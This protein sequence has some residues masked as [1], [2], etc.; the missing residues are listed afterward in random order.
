MVVLSTWLILTALSVIHGKLTID[1]SNIA[2]TLFGLANAT[3]ALHPAET[4]HHEEDHTITSFENRNG[5]VNPEDLNAMPQCV[6]QQDQSAWLSAMTRCT[7]RQCTRH[8]GVVCTHHQW[9]TQL[10]CLSTAFSPETVTSYLP[11][12]SRS[13]LAKA[14]LFRWILAATGRTWLVHVG[15]ASGLQSLTPASLPEGYAAVGVIEKAPAC[16]KESQNGATMEPFQ[17]VIASCSFTSQAQHTGNAARPWEYSEYFHSMVALDFETA[18]YDL[19][20]RRIADGDYFDKAC[21]C[22]TLRTDL[23]TES[24]SCQGLDTTKERLWLNATCG[25]EL[26]PIGWQNELKTTTFAFIPTR[27][28]R[29]PDC[30]DNLPRRMIQLADHCT[31]DACNVDSEG[32][33]RVERAIDRAQFCRGVAYSNCKGPCRIFEARIQYV[34]WLHD[35]CGGVEG[36]RGLPKHWRQLAAPTPIEMIPWRWNIRASKHSAVGNRHSKDSAYSVST[37]WKVSSIVL[38]NLATLLTALYAQSPTS[39][40]AVL[41]NPYFATTQHCFVSGLTMATIHLSANWVNAILVQATA[42]YEAV[43]IV[44]LILLW[45]TMPRLTWLSM[46]LHIIRPS[47]GTSIDRI[48]SCVVVETVLQVMSAF[49]MLQTVSYG[50]EH[51]FYTPGMARLDAA[52]SAKYMYA[53]A[54]TWLLVTIISIVLLLQLTWEATPESEPHSRCQTAASVSSRSF[55]RLNGHWIRFEEVLARH[56]FANK[57][58]NTEREPLLHDEARDYGTLLATG[59]SDRRAAM[60]T[61]RFAV[62][63]IGTMFFLWIAQW[64]FWAGYIQLASDEYVST[65]AFLPM[66]DVSILT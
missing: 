10:T 19:T 61:V 21:F 17:H 39:A 42:G 16:L 26:L 22:K 1:V 34:N 38:V 53:G 49:I 57:L 12:C 35:V 5:W 63:T 46:I 3:K 15:D 27:E 8:F 60:R 64:L 44:Q 32:Y 11:F 40:A 55:N 50:Q 56:C 62:L 52:P 59:S 37:D 48:V 45:S 43:S 47:R 2:L 51:N 23:Q 14:Q 58:G 4:D 31:T 36:W 24:N 29:W 28:W 18:G 9:L 7:G 6:A 65:R 33:C 13:V 66:I 25:P 54:A 30:K 41:P 20:Q